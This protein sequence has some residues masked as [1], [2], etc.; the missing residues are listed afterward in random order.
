M[1]PRISSPAHPHEPAF[2]LTSTHTMSLF[3]AYASIRAWMADDVDNV[4]HAPSLLVTGSR[5]E[6]SALRSPSRPKLGS[7]T[8]YQA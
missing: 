8:R 2:L 7:A 3:P 5:S 1:S 6:V 4:R